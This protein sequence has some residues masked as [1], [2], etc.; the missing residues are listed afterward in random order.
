MS[1]LNAAL[2][3]ADAIARYEALVD[4]RKAAQSR[5]AWCDCCRVWVEKQSMAQHLT[6]QVHAAAQRRADAWKM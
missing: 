4:R 6:T 5:E 2:D 3:R 1:K